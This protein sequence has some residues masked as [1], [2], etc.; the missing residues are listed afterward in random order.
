MSTRSA[1]PTRCRYEDVPD[2][3]PKQGEALVRADA[4]GVNFIDIYQRTGVYKIPTP[5]TLGSE[6]A[7]TVVALGPEVGQFKVGDKVA[8]A[9]VLGSYAEMSAVPAAKLVK[10]PAGVSTKQGAAVMLQGMT[11]HYLA[12]STSPLKVGDTCLVHAGAGGVG[13]LLTQIAKIRGARVITTVSSDEKAKLSR[14][15]GADDVVLTRAKT[16]KRPSC[17]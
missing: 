5:F 4:A 1:I 15:A 13:L 16:S 14:D 9:G 7:G 2:P 6:G 17:C 8:W 11:A 10:L 12:C 3:T